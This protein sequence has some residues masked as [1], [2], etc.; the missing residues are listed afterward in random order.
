MKPSQLLLLT[1]LLL[2]QGCAHVQ[3][4]NEPQASR[5]A[6]EQAAL[7]LFE[8]NIEAIQRKDREAYLA[9]YRQ[10]EGLVRA[11]P[12]GPKLGYA[13]LADGTSPSGSDEWPSSLIA[14]QLQVH[15]LRPGV[16]Y[17]SYAYTVTIAGETSKGI[18]ERV[19][20][21]RDGRWAIAVTTAF[22]APAQAD[23]APPSVQAPPTASDA[24]P[25]AQQPDE[26]Q[27]A[28]P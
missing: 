27:P 19:F 3:T 7:A 20:L 11:G 4:P 28:E 22:P 13:E 2:V 25:Q 17:G 16:V 12:E 18:S 15:W 21:E 5:E 6:D 26:Q 10:D 24:A 23:T 8:R 14:D 9:C 1:T